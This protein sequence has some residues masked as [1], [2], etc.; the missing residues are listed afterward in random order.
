[1][2]ILILED[3]NKNMY[4]L[5]EYTK[6]SSLSKLQEFFIIYHFNKI[7]KYFL[8]MLRLW[9]ELLKYILSLQFF[10]KFLSNSVRLCLIIV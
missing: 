6:F 1:M 2:K 9:I 10:L 5:N 8:K 7:I 3:F 4:F